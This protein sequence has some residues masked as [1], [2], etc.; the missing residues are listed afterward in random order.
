MPL[1]SVITYGP[2]TS[3]A[4]YSI[5]YTKNPLILMMAMSFS[6]LVQVYV[7]E[8]GMST[9]ATSLCS[10]VSTIHVSRTYLVAT[11]DEISSYLDIKSL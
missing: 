4:I 8:F 2:Y 10:S 7:K 3:G 6:S 5:I 1:R 9:V 11:V